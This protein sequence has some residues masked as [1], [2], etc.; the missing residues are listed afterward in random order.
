MGT[1]AEKVL[2]VAVEV[3]GGI[4]GA[5][6]GDETL[7]VVEADEAA[8]ADHFADHVIGE[9]PLVGADGSGVGVGRDEWTTGGF[10]DIGVS[11]VV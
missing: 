9:V 11:C 2:D 4:A 7:A 6:I 10:E 8:A 5:V 3:I 1:E